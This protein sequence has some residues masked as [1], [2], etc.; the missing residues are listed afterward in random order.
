MR[1]YSDRIRAQFE[2]ALEEVPDLPASPQHSPGHAPAVRFDHT[3]AARP[4][5]APAITVTGP[6]GS[7][8]HAAGVHGVQQFSFA[9][10]P[11]PGPLH[12]RDLQS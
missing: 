8:A 5:T 11:S 3:P 4:G 12:P 1:I 2:H 9:G 10:R 6:S 7:Q